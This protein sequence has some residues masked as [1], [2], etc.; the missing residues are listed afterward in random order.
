M[1][2]QVKNRRASIASGCLRRQSRALF[3][4]FHGQIS[5]EASIKINGNPHNERP[6]NCQAEPRVILGGRLNADSGNAT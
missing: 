4:A 5:T 3:P 1:A 6:H 2:A